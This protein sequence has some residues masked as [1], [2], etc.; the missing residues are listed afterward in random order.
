MKR[1]G[2]GYGGDL[3]ANLQARFY[4]RES[5]RAEI[6]RGGKSA[7]QRSYVRVWCREFSVRRKK[8]AGQNLRTAFY[9]TYN[10]NIGPGGTWTLWKNRWWIGFVYVGSTYGIWR[11]LGEYVSLVGG[12]RHWGES[13]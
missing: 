9:G 10:E 11:I 3:W 2:Y 13:V 1:V 8:S 5:T 6:V 12:T 7:G 4:V